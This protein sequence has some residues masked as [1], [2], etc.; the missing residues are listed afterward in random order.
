MKQRAR[1]GCGFLSSRPVPRTR[2][3]P[4]RPWLSELAAGAL[5]VAGDP[6]LSNRREQIVALASRYAVPSSYRWP[7]FGTSGGL[8]ERWM[9]T[10]RRLSPGRHLRWEGPQGASRPICRS[11]NLSFELVI[12]RN[13]KSARPHRAGIRR[14]LAATRLSSKARAPAGSRPESVLLPLAY[15]TPEGRLVYAGTGMTRPNWRRY[16]AG[17]PLPRRGC[18]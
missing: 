7:E 2:S 12:N 13:C 3:R 18:R 1:R 10:G 4:L 14:R 9:S 6:F 11:S 8:I 16:A 15:Y 5:L 17:H